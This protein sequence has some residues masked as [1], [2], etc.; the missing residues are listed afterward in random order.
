MTSMGG[1]RSLGS[2]GIG[3]VP[4]RQLR[5]DVPRCGLAAVPGASRAAM[6]PFFDWGRSPWVELD[7][8]WA[9]V[10]ACPLRWWSNRC[11][12]VRRDAAR[13]GLRLRS[14]PRVMEAPVP[15][16]RW[17]HQAQPPRTLRR[18]GL[19]L[20]PAA[21]VEP[22]RPPHRLPVRMVPH[23]NPQAPLPAPRPRVRAQPIPTRAIG[24]L[25]PDPV[26]PRSFS[27]PMTSSRTARS[28]TEV[29]PTQ[30]ITTSS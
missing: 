28:W 22:G 17:S 6:E 21:R 7:R 9:S 29:P 16:T 26:D 12:G 24:R 25:K 10:S 14:L 30:I 27:S 18:P 23:P 4:V 11:G 20:S 15:P 2:F 19:R 13:Q 3:N 8:L 1:R 5:R